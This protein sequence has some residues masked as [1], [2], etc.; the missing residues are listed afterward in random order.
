LIVV[1]GD[2]AGDLLTRPDSDVTW[3]V[4]VGGVELGR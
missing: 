1:D 4:V 3:A 2:E